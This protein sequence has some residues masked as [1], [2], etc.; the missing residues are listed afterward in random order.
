MRVEEIDHWRFQLKVL[1]KTAERQLNEEELWLRIS[2]RLSLQLIEFS[3]KWL[4][5][6]AHRAGY[7]HFKESK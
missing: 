2:P 6:A 3:E 5:E 7:H 4:I 1:R